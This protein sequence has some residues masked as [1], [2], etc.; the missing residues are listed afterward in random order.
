MFVLCSSEVTMLARRLD[1]ALDALAACRDRLSVLREVFGPG[2][3]ER[4]AVDDLLAAM[5]RADAVILTR[6]PTTDV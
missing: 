1:S 4:A 5:E 3:P 6:R 2:A